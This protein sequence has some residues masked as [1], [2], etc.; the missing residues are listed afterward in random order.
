MIAIVLSFYGWI[1][2]TTLRRYKDEGELSYG[3]VHV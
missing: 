3:D 1:L 2:Y